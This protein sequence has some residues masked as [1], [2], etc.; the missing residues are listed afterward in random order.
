MVLFAWA[1]TVDQRSYARQADDCYD[2]I[3]L[4]STDR[5]GTTGSALSPEPPVEWHVLVEAIRRYCPAAKAR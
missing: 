5:I 1:V 2:V 4:N 3:V